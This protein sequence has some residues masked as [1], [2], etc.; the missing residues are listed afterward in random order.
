MRSALTWSRHRI[1]ANA[2]WPRAEANPRFIVTSLSRVEF[3]SR[4]LYENI[5]NSSTRYA[6]RVGFIN[7]TLRDS[8]R[9]CYDHQPK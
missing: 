9:L 4:F 8:N 1:V 2:E 3:G 5:Y 7:Q 6:Q